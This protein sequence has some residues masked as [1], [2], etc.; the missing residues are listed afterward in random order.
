MDAMGHALEHWDEWIDAWIS[1]AVLG[2]CR[3][4]TVSHYRARIRAF[5]RYTPL[6]P[7]EV[8]ASDVALWLDRPGPST[9]TR[10]LDRGILASF[11]QWA[12]AKGLRDDPMAFIPAIGRTIT[13]SDVASEE[14]M[15]QGRRHWDARAQIM[16]MLAGDHGLRRSEI[17]TLR[18]TDLQPAVDGWVLVVSGDGLRKRSV[19][20]GPELARMILRR[21]IGY[22]F[23]G[24]RGCAHVCEDTVWR[25]IKEATGCSPTEL[26]RR[27]VR[28][29]LERCD[30]DLLAVA[31]LMGLTAES[32][33]ELADVRR[34][35][36]IRISHGSG[37]G[38]RYGD[39]ASNEPGIVHGIRCIHGEGEPFGNRNGIR[40]GTGG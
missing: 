8:D 15:E 32:V 39:G 21:G 12:T 3:A 11:F 28:I 26:R 40:T 18:G 34:V 37:D 13:T 35:R 30:G 4:S 31:D 38:T 16:V 7:D 24:E 1:D 14:S 5:A 22:T 25:V 9:N 6:E 27:Y 20:V 29:A 19:P 23:P 33:L 2:R 10:S 17:A 36:G